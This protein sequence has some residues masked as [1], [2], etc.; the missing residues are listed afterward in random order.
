MKPALQVIA[1]IGKGMIVDKDMLDFLIVIIF[2]EH[3]ILILRYF[4]REMIGDMAP[5]VIKKR[6]NVVHEIEEMTHK[7]K[8][9]AQ[10]N[11]IN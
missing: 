9:I 6:G 10:N 1:N 3:L 8:E 7:Q 5:W 4:L 2:T 11:L